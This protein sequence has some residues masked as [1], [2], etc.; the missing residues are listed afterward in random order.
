M[1]EI[2]VLEAVV[3]I[4]QVLV[5]ELNNFSNEHLEISKTS[6]SELKATW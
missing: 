6:A 3:D 2:V 5:M 4:V 1:E